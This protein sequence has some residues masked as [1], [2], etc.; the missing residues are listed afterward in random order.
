MFS[1]RFFLYS[2]LIQFN[3]AETEFIRANKPKEAILMY[4]HCRD[5]RAASRV[6]EQHLPSAIDEVL[7]SQAA[8]AFESRN[9]QEYE[10]LMIRAGRTDIVLQHYKEREMWDDALR[11][12]KEYIPSA[13]SEI[14]QMQL[15][16]TIDS[17]SGINDSNDSRQLLQEASTHAQ[18]ERFRKAINCLL[19]INKSNADEL[20]VEQAMLR[21]A[22]M[23][24]QFLEGNDAVEV[25]DELAPRLM[26]LNHIGQ[27][28]QL[29]L[30]AEKPKEA[31]DVF[32]RTENWSK[33]RRLAKEIDS[34]LLTYVEEQQKVKLRTEGNVDH[35]ADIGKIII[36]HFSTYNKI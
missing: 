33:A 30:A 26:Q 21:A 17:N 28:V 14:Q 16:S 4:T 27:A 22:E 18:N 7:I 23:S 12:A 6:A 15:K 10:V 9:Y 11:I 25:A 2:L 5:W 24:N 13:I 32:I 34:Q 8:A 3:E 20:M 1:F 36:V 29:Y 19:K 35:L 31:I